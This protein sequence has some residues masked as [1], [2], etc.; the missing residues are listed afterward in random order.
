MTMLTSLQD[1][2]TGN[3]YLIN[4]KTGSFVVLMTPVQLA[5]FKSNLNIGPYSITINDNDYK[6]EVTTELTDDYLPATSLVTKKRY[7]PGSL[8]AGI[9]F[10][11]RR[12]IKKLGKWFDHHTPAAKKFIEAY[13]DPDV[14]KASHIFKSPMSGIESKLLPGYIADQGKPKAE[15]EV[16]PT[17]FIPGITP[18]VTWE[19]W[20]ARI[21]MWG[22]FETYISTPNPETKLTPLEVLSSLMED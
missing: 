3:D 17:D 21:K 15:R 1:A 8:G 19:E 16:S 5:K 10:V 9:S 2:F 13:L 20:I 12:T 7:K 4:E 18:Q 14:A 22:D 11:D 6:V